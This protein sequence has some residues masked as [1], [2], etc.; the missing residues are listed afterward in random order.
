MK[1]VY[2]ILGATTDFSNSD[3]ISQGCEGQTHLASGVSHQLKLRQL[4]TLLHR[5]G[6]LRLNIYTHAGKLGTKALVA[7]HHGNSIER[8]LWIS[9]SSADS[10]S[11]NSHTT[12][13]AKTAE[14]SWSVPLKESHNKSAKT[15][16]ELFTQA[17]V[18]TKETGSRTLCTQVWP[19]LQ[20]LQ[21]QPSECG[22][23]R[24]V[25]WCHLACEVPGRSLPDV[26]L[27][28]HSES[29]NHEQD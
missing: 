3:N 4:W 8:H 22:N 23:Y 19:E 26:T 5:W 14:I 17:R 15:P 11:R 18:Y 24:P 28:S 10:A 29:C 2:W 25:L 16:S 13:K 21:L 20:V 12:D 6:R 7:I 9:V 1:L 27:L